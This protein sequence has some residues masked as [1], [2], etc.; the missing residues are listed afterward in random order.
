MLYK[1]LPALV[2]LL[3]SHCAMRISAQT[4]TLSVP[5]A[6]AVADNP[7]GAWTEAPGCKILSY[8]STDDS[9]AYVFQ[10]ILT[11]DAVDAGVN[12][13]CQACWGNLDLCSMR[14]MFLDC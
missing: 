1:D 9:Q 2:T 3:L 11:I 10:T 6:S 12:A 14:T 7:T 13:V 4:P 5:S 8:F